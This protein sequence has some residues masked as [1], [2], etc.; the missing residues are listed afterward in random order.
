MAMSSYL[1]QEAG[2]RRLPGMNWWIATTFSER[3]EVIIPKDGK[4][5]SSEDD[6]VWVVLIEPDP[7]WR[8]PPKVTWDEFAIG[9]YLDELL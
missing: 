5:L 9:Y 6:E 7:D 4:E 1:L 3:C 2:F 8:R